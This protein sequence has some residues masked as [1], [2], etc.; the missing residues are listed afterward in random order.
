M[1]NYLCNVSSETQPVLLKTIKT[2]IANTNTLIHFCLIGTSS[3]TSINI[4]AA[5]SSRKMAK[6]FFFD[7]FRKASYNN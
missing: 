1:I 3:M 4:I 2:M 7:K 5:N 6:I